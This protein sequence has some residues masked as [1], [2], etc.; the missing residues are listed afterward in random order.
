MKPDVGSEPLLDLRQGAD[1]C[2]CSPNTFRERLL[3]LTRAIDLSRPGAKRRRLRFT[4]AALREALA[5][6]ESTDR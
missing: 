2:G 3:P 1:F 5:S 4:P 6:L